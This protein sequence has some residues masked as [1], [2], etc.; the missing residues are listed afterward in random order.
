[1]MG[2]RN[3][4]RSRRSPCSAGCI[5]TTARRHDHGGPR[6]GASTT[7]L[8]IPYATW[9]DVPMN[10]QISVAAVVLAA[11]FTFN[12]SNASNG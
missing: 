10:R 5:M 7:G 4:S 11:G 8:A 9:K 12:C 1:M 6:K 3:S 2:A